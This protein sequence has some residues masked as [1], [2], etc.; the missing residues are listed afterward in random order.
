MAWWEQRSRHD[1]RRASKRTFLGQVITNRLLDL[2]KAELA[3][4]RW[5]DR[6]ARSLGLDDWDLKRAVEDV[7]AEDP[8]QAA[9]RSEMAQRIAWARERLPVRERAVLDG[10]LLEKTPSELSRELGTSRVTVYSDRKRIREALEAE[11]LRDFIQ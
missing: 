10:L 4:K 9:E 1:E 5:A 2:L 6:S 3:E 11:G 8:Q 7:Q